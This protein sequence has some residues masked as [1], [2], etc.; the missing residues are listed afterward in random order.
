MDD[1]SFD[2]IVIGGGAAGL[3]AALTLARARRSVLV[4]DGGEPRNAPA[5]GV[6]GFLSR[7][8]IAPADLIRL[9]TAEVTRYGGRILAASVTSARPDGSGF[10]VRTGD[11][12]RFAARRLLL[13]TGLV[14]ELPDIPG[15]RQRWG[16]DVLHC[17]HCHGW[18]VRDQPIG[19]LGT[20]PHAVRQALL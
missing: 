6:H 3:S 9:G 11:G 13:C 8:G 12:R 18:E 14:D 1:F 20:G 17:P 16:R 7:D 19:V 4:L 5:A 2:V 10:A 15:L